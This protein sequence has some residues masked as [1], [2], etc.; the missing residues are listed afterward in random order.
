MASDPEHVTT[1]AAL[2]AMALIR[3]S[4]QSALLARGMSI[5]EVTE[6]TEEANRAKTS[7][8]AYLKQ[9]NEI[10]AESGE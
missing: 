9:A 4:F 5:D 2:D 6:I 10:L 1:A 8:I 3:A 7:M